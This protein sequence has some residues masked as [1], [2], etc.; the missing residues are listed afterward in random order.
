[1]SVH[2]GLTGL[3]STNYDLVFSQ[4][5]SKF[6]N[7]HIPPL[8]YNKV[9]GVPEFLFGGIIIFVGDKGGY[10][11]HSCCKISIIIKLLFIFGKL[12]VLFVLLFFLNLLVLF[13]LFVLLVLLVL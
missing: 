3:M 8:K 4:E 13:V 2:K 6:R 10:A 7:F 12:L 11:L 9:G 5:Y 1:M